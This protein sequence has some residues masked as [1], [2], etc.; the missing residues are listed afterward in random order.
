M[1]WKKVK[2]ILIYV[3]LC[4]NIFLAGNIVWQI[5][6]DRGAQA[7]AFNLALDMLSQTV[8]QLDENAFE[9]VKDRTSIAVS[10]RSNEKEKS[11]AQSLI[12]TNTLGVAGGGIHFFA[13]DTGKATFRSGGMMEIIWDE[14][15][16][17]DKTQFFEKKLKEAGLD[18]SASNSY[19]QNGEVTFYQTAYDGNPIENAALV[20][21]YSDGACTVSGRW[22]AG[23]QTEQSR[24]KT[25]HEM[26]L[27]LNGYLNENNIKQ[28]LQSV[29]IVYFAD[30][31]DEQE[32]TLTPAWHVIMLNTDF[33]LNCDNGKEITPA[34]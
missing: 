34:K 27:V 19:D 24:G 15:A 3:L 17:G 4:T 8:P 16:R 5:V 18:V 26:L 13:S 32:I 14:E 12:K 20:C 6:Q 28:Q 10:P 30:G 29:E 7:K 25:S 23:A 21:T 33:Y 1:E 2:T 22:I 9:R 11:I 31:V